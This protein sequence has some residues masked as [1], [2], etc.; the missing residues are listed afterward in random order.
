[1]QLN[2]DILR[3]YM[4]AAPLA[5]AFE[6][7]MECLILAD[8]P[9]QRP[10]LDIGCGDGLF[11]KILFPEMIDTGIDP[12]LNELEQAGK[13]NVYKEL[14]HCSGAAIPKPGGF[15]KTILSNSV[16]E[17]IPDLGAVLNEAHRLLAPGG[18][19]YF[20]VPSD[21]FESYTVIYQLLNAMRCYGWAKRFGRFFN[22]FWRH[23][24]CYPADQWEEIAIKVGFEIVDRYSYGP[25][26]ICILNDML[27]LLSVPA[28]ATK[29][30][31]NRWT[32]FPWL[33]RMT[34]YPIYLT[35]LPSIQSGVKAESGGL[36]FLA[37]TKK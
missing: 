26:H 23:Y 15:Y 31:V 17:H 5:L 8:Q 1:M 36:V 11:A 34:L 14:I 4:V 37:L 35:A 20:T 22:R 21:L 3:E 12:N 13:L 27:T 10:I 32:L 33:R 25:R 18:R 28:L 24:H 30:L 19:F 6:R 9:F 16:I 2:R 29:K 7:T